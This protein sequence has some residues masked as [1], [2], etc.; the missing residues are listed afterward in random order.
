MLRHITFIASGAA[1]ALAIAGS[2]FAAD[3][4]KAISPDEAKSKQAYALG[5]TAYIWAIPWW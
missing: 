5:V 4:Q 2:S 3:D 1:M